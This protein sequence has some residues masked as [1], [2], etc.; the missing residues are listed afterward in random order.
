[1]KYDE[2]IVRD[3]VDN[4][5][6]IFEDKDFGL[7][8]G[9]SGISLY[10]VL[11]GFYNKNNDIIDYGFDLFENCFCNIELS[12][13]YSDFESGITGLSWLLNYYEKMGFIGKD[14]LKSLA[15]FSDFLHI[16]L[17]KCFEKNIY[18]FFTGSTGISWY[19]SDV[20]I[21]DK[22]ARKYLDFFVIKFKE[23]CDIDYQTGRIIPQNE[24]IR[25][26]DISHIII[27][28]IKLHKEFKKIN[29]NTYN[30]EALVSGLVLYVEHIISSG[31]YINSVANSHIS[32][33]TYIYVCIAFFQYYKLTGNLKYYKK[34][35]H[36]YN[37]L[38]NSYV[39]YGNSDNV[40]LT[41]IRRSS[42]NYELY[43]Y[44]QQFS[45]VLDDRIAV[46]RCKNISTFKM[47]N[48]NIATGTAGI[49]LN[50]LNDENC[51]PVHWD[52]IFMFNNE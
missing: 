5:L 42:K 19:L 1:M 2:V 46:T 23:N 8:T 50:L 15:N 37:L 21:Y 12:K 3:F 33:S 34:S 4:K 39:Y 17:V 14:N 35:Q 44:K 49:G 47:S 16:E 48:Y 11:Y 31:E 9:S 7:L 20:L 24:D 45:R 28:L 27:L 41:F 26:I 36:I 6:K 25:L 29:F 22:C 52:G 18:D 32:H 10:L 30:V 40:L 38:I 13:I 51:S 43:K